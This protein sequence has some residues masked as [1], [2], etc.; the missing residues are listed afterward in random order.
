MKQIDTVTPAISVV[1]LDEENRILLQKRTDSGVWALPSGHIEPGESV[2]DAAIREIYEE[3]NLRINIKK[4]I[5]VYSDPNYQVY[6]YP[7][8]ERK[9]FI[10][11]CFL[12]EITGGVFRINPKESLDFKFFHKDAF[13]ANILT[14]HPNFINDLFSKED[15]SFIR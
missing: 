8:G 3:T 5:G 9:H 1:I 13:P 12:A 10:T 14:M 11:T 6:T 15:I 2:S 7:S 4:L